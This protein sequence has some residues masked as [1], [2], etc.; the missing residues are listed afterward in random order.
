MDVTAIFDSLNTFFNSPV[1][2]AVLWATMVGLFMFLASRF[3]P[4]QATW[5]AWE[6]SIITGIKLAEK[7]IDDDT[8]NAGLAKLDAALRFVLKAYAEANG[9]K[10][11]SAKVVEQLK[12]GIQITHADL[13][14]FGGLSKPKAAAG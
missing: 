4:F 14:R 10:Q 11:P 7:E 3:N 8:P 5:K 13:D 1:G 12:Q 9:G 6:G 2:F